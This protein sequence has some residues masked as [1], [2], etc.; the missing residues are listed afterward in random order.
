MSGV[1]EDRKM[2]F[3]ILLPTREAI[4][5]GRPDPAPALTQDRRTS[6]H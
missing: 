2:K 4:M 3:G 5:S 1:G 6:K